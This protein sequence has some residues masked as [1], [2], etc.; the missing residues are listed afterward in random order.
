[1]FTAGRNKLNMKWTGLMQLS[2]RTSPVLEKRGHSDV[3]GVALFKHT[4]F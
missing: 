2:N 3:E 1:M 4:K